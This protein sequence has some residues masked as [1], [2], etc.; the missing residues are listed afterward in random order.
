LTLLL[1]F[2]GLALFLAALGVYA[3]VAHS[4]ARRN[5][6]LAIRI[7]LGAS[8]GT[9][10]GA[11]MRQAL[12]PVIAGLGGGL[13]TAVVTGPLLRSLLFHVNPTNPAV[14]VAAVATVGTA[15]ACA[16]LGPAYRAT[17]TDPLRALRAE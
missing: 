17:R 6:E 2:A 8:A 15:A 12:S 5:K 3:L 4:V 7:S 14:L 1:L 13:T 9:I 11:V 10:W 16:C